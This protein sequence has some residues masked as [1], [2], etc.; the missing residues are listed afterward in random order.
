MGMKAHILCVA[1]GF[2]EGK[3]APKIGFNT[4]NGTLTD[5]VTG[6]LWV[7]PRRRLEELKPVPAMADPFALIQR[8]TDIVGKVE[9]RPNLADLLKGDDVLSK[10]FR[11][12]QV[13]AGATEY[14]SFIQIIPYYLFRNKGRFLHYLRPDKGNETRL[15]GKVSIGVGGHIDV[16][17]VITNEDGGIDLTATL[18]RSGKREG[19]EEIGIDIADDSFRFI[20]TIYATDTEVDRVHLGIVGICDLTDEQAEGLTVN[21]E[22]MDHGFK[23][24]AEI[25]SETDSDPLKTLETWTRL[26][27]ES[28]PLA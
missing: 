15:H 13:E 21:E 12:G 1:A 23:T 7:G 8:M 24:L 22:I 20:G 10:L 4:M 16:A 5:V 28:N 26:V 9:G 2:G 11:T 3:Y 14:P 17:D 6:D 27:I 18:V 25:R 19:S